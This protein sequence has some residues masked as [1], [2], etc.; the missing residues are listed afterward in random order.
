M[1]IAQVLAIITG[2]IAIFS[3]VVSTVSV[4]NLIKFR[5]DAMGKIEGEIRADLRAATDS[6]NTLI[7]LVKVQQASQEIINKVTTDTL[8]A[9]LRRVEANENQ[10]NK[11]NNERDR[12]RS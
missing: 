7:T 2:T 6:L 3:A 11:I 9:L 4:I 10:I 5:T 8:A 1:E 12:E